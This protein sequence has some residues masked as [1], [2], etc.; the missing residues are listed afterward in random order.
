MQ[1]CGRSC[2]PM[3][4]V[5]DESKKSSFPGGLQCFWFQV[6]RRTSS[7]KSPRNLSLVRSQSLG[8][9]I[10]CRIKATCPRGIPGHFWTWY[11]LWQAQI[12]EHI[13]ASP[14]LILRL[15]F[16]HPLAWMCQHWG[17]YDHVQTD[18][19]A[20]GL[21]VFVQ[22]AGKSNDCTGLV[23]R[24]RDPGGFRLEE[25]YPSSWVFVVSWLHPRRWRA[26]DDHV[27]PLKKTMK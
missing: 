1:S 8:Q 3:L 10:S 7:K 5:T 14:T 26:W 19:A 15:I 12:C 22:G 27:K 2:S 23:T 13:F 20:P 24:A 4:G 18:V 9:V 25:V 16:L 17:N 21:S 6:R 11:P